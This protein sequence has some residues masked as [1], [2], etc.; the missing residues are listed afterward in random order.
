MAGRRRAAAIPRLD[1]IRLDAS[2]F[3]FALGVTLLVAIGLAGM[4]AF[5]RG[6]AGGAAA[7]VEGGRSSTVGRQRLRVRSTLVAGQV[8]L[9]LVLITSAGLLLESF[10][11]LRAV[12]PGVTTAGV[13]TL[14][15]HV[16]STRYGTYERR[17]QFYG[18]MLERV[19]ALPGV[20][21]AGVSVN[22]PFRGGYGC[23]VQG[24]EDSAVYGRLDD[25]GLTTCAAA[26]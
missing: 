12:D 21:A 20:I 2:V 13:L 5:R 17:W 7:L 18:A 19:R 4:A 26:S 15:V 22:I 25:A 6:A 9:A 10:R 8:A 14:E 3:G 24:F 23:T 16:P 11:R 1:A